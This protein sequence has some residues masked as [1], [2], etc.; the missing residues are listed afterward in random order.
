M[1]EIAH[2]RSVTSS[3]VMVSVS[4]NDGNV[5]VIRTVFMVWTRKTAVRI[6]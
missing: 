4:P 5:T 6:L 3:A 2:A 1:N